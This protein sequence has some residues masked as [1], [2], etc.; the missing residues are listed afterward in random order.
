MVQ[1]VGAGFQNSLISSLTNSPTYDNRIVS[2]SVM[3]TAG[4]GLIIQTIAI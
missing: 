2:R 1:C 3:D 4:S